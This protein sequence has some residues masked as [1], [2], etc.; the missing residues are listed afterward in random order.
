MCECKLYVWARK[1]ME[2]FLCVL[3]VAMTRNFT[4]D[5]VHTISVSFCLIQ[6]LHLLFDFVCI[7]SLL[8]IADGKTKTTTTHRPTSESSTSI[9]MTFWNVNIECEREINTHS[10]SS[11]CR[12]RI[13]HLAIQR[14]TRA[15][16]FSDFRRRRQ[17]T[18]CFF[19]SVFHVRQPNRSHESRFHAETY[20]T[21]V[22]QLYALK[23]WASN[24]RPFE[25]DLVHESKIP[26]RP[27]WNWTNEKKKKRKKKTNHYV[28]QH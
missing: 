25:S 20:R 5:A 11:R 24:F 28:H 15:D 9:W 26:K 21:P 17:A 4:L 13:R 12:I 19:F 1:K 6:F 3:V 16:R 7:V 14:K 2:I 27:K 22:D 23:T 18:T 10:E 8:K